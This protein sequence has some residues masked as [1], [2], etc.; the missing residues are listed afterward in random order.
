MEFPSES[1]ER[2]FWASFN[3]GLEK[4]AAGNKW[5]LVKMMESGI[6][7]KLAAISRLPA[8]A[9]QKARSQLEQRL[10]RLRHTAENV[11][12]DRLDAAKG[13]TGGAKSVKERNKGI[14][15][16]KPHERVADRIASLNVPTSPVFPEKMKDD[17]L[18][19]GAG[20]DARVPAEHRR[21]IYKTEM[22]GT[23]ATRMG[24]LILN[25]R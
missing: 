15:A 8:S 21:E 22:P 5:N 10:Y 13:V 19:R 25:A 23:R 6:K 17:L 3:D 7:S 9:Q 11:F 4:T 12:D 2:Q 14:M 24:P 20:W 1:A 18:S 16:A